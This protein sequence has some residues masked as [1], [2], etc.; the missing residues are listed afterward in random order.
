MAKN[1]GAERKHDIRIAERK[2]D[3]KSAEGKQD[4]AAQSETLLQDGG[5]QRGPMGTSV[6]KGL[7]AV[8]KIVETVLQKHHAEAESFDLRRLLSLVM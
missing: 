1:Y 3:P 4:Q 7:E 8:C 6:T 2:L 5:E